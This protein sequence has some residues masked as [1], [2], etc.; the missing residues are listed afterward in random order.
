MV[1]KFDWQGVSTVSFPTLVPILFSYFGN[2][3]KNLSALGIEKS[4]DS[5]Y[6]FLYLRRRKPSLYSC[7]LKETFLRFGPFPFSLYIVLL[8][9]IN[10]LT[11]SPGIFYLW[12]DGESWIERHTG[13]L[14]RISVW[15]GCPN[16]TLDEPQDVKKY[17]CL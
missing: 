1:K 4:R 11:F 10:P 12:N 16:W 8:F 9:L 17:H 7:R 14:L 3:N 13:L 6:D 2:P 15:V 5:V